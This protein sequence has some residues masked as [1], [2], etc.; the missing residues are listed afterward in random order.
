M[1]RP[2]LLPALLCAAV[3]LSAQGKVNP[4]LVR[5]PADDPTAA[6]VR[7][8]GISGAV[9]KA[10]PAIVHVFVEVDGERGRFAIERCSSGV[11]VDSSGLVLTLHRLVQESVG[12]TDK[13][14]CVQLDDATHTQLPATVAKTDADTGLVLL[15]V[16][17]PE[18]GLAHVELGPD[19][20]ATGQ[21]LAVLACPEGKDV[22][23]FAGVASPALAD[24]QL[25]G[26][27]AAAKDVFLTDSKQDQ[28]CDGGAVID[29]EGRL[30][31]LFDAERVLRDPSEPTLEDLKKP[32]FGV[33]RPAG[34]VRRAFAAEFAGPAA[35]NPGL[36]AAPAPS[37]TIAAVARVAPSVL[38]FFGGEG[39]WPVLPADDPGAVQRRAGLGSA[40][41]VARDL[42]ITNAHLCAG[43]GGRLR[44][45]DGRTLPAAVVKRNEPANLVL[46]RAELPAG[47]E[48]VPAPAAADDDVQLGETVYALGN[49]LGSAVVVTMGVVSAR[50]GREGGRIQADPNLGNQNGGGA[51]V[52]ATG[53]L[54]GIADGGAIDPLELAFA[55]RGDRAS[56]E[57]NL[58]T[59]VGIA[60]VRSLFATELAGA[61]PATA[62][63][64]TARTSPLVR[65]V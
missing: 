39:D 32:S 18:N 5:A 20:P 7:R 63:D 24:V 16:T 3:P 53:R 14:L 52:D 48:L 43:K 17:P 35:K 41:A 60:R 12:A 28:R 22:L 25:G 21:P 61:L 34:A 40:V 62:G 10:R 36:R 45:P 50:R 47:V 54:V 23:G 30:L 8:S 44:L 58:S 51:C 55:M 27:R 19:R 37:P 57:T 65:M 38:G 26:R 31:G 13:R 42:A 2:F 29:A 6:A 56:A 64:R 4:S 33:V 1:L 15:R 11:V 59:F 46:L 49:P 9:A